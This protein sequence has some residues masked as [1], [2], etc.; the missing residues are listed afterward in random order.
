MVM[1][2][3]PSICRFGDDSQNDY[4]DQEHAH[5]DELLD[6]PIGQRPKFQR[7]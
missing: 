2:P 7:A 6:P 4:D 3:L 1:P 5:G